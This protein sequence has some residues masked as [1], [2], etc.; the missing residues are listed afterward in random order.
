MGIG[1]NLTSGGRTYVSSYVEG[2]YYL[3]DAREKRT[4]WEGE[5]LVT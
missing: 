2:T 1:W 4:I 5:V 3:I